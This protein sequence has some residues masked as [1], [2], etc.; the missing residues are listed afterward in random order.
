[1]S[2]LNIENKQLA[3]GK[4]SYENPHRNPNQNPNTFRRNNQQFQILKKERNPTEDQRVKSP[5]QNTVMDEFED[6]FQEEEED[7][8]HCVGDDAKKSYLTQKDYEEALRIQ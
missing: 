6:D 7:N 5:L 3:Q 2:K 8:I 1:M 4:S